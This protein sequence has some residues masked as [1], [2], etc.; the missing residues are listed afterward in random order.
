MSIGRNEQCS[1]GSG[2]KYKRC[3]LDADRAAERMRGE[4]PPEL[5]REIEATIERSSA[6]L[7]DRGIYI[8]YVAPVVW[9]GRKFFAIGSRLYPDRPLEQTFSEFLLTVLRQTLGAEWWQAQEELPDADRHF[10]KECWDGYRRWRKD[11]SVEAN[12]QAKGVWATAPSGWTQALALLAWDIATLIHA[13][14]LPEDLL[15]RLKDRTQYQGARYEIATA[16]IFARLDCEI[17]FLDAK[18]ELRSTKHAEFI[19]THRPSGIAVAVEAKSRHRA[20]VINHAGEYDEIRAVRGDVRG[21]FEK[22]LPKAPEGMPFLVFIDVN[23]YVESDDGFEQQWRKDVQDWMESVHPGTEAG[24]DVYS[25]LALMNH[26]PHYQGD[27]IALG[28]QWTYVEPPHVRQPLDSD[29]AAM[30]RTAL[31]HYH[32][33]PEIAPGGEI[34]E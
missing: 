33:V 32:R 25:G 24:P 31:D 2:K 34:L 22:A 29:F 7:R 17:D 10:I 28:T 27:D 3:H 16:A 23:A 13:A 30:L 9:E 26:A 12:E 5:Q 15:A 21:L 20:G 6:G 11:Q 8:N 1:C 4:M 18:P 19:A 14:E